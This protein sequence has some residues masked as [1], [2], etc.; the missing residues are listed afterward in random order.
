RLGEVILLADLLQDV[1]GR[2][3]VEYHD[4]RLVTD[5]RSLGEGIDM[6]VRHRQSR[7]GWGHGFFFSL[8]NSSDST[9]SFPG[10]PTWPSGSPCISS[11]ISGKAAY[12]TLSTRS[13]I[14]CASATVIAGGKST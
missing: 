12:R 14:R 4:R 5:E 13:M 7:L 9:S 3:F 11:S 8:A 2:P 6:P 1:I 10:S